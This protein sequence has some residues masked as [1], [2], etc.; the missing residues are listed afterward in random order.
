[1][2]Y[3]TGSDFHLPYGRIESLPDAPRSDYERAEIRQNV[4]QSGVNPARGKTKLVVWMVSNCNPSSNRFEYVKEMQKYATV[5]IIS[6]KGRCGGQ[7][8][9]PKKLND[10]VCYDMLERT[11]KFYLA[12]ENSICAEYVTEKFFN[13]IGRNIV[14]VVLGG[15]NY[16]SLAPQHSYINALDYTPQQLVEYLKL[17]D[18]ND[19]L[20]AEYF[21]WKPFYRV[22]NLQQTNVEAFC[23]FCAALHA[24]PLQ[25]KVTRNLQ[26]WYHSDSHCVTRPKFTSNDSA[27]AQNTL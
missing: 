6:S 20:Y 26:Q 15:A 9:C 2:T 19:N 25:S 17:L 3:L 23:Q 22:L 24:V 1:M 4:L 8:L 18:S 11:Y 10:A 12:F 7:D 27:E 21:W 16:S 14:P 13:M 5:D